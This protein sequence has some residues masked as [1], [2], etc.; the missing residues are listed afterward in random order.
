MI[1]ILLL[2]ANLLTLYQKWKNQ[3]MLDGIYVL[4]YMLDCLYVDI[5]L[6]MKGKWF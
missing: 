3:K 2:S 5:N 4:N 6:N 1:E